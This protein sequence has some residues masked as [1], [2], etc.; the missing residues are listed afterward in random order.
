MPTAL[1]AWRTL[2]DGRDRAEFYRMW[3]AGTAAG[4]TVPAT[5][6]AMGPRAAA[7]VEE[8][9]SWLLTG[10]RDGRDVGSLVRLGRSRFDA[11]ESTLLLLGDETGSLE[12]V[13]RL[14]AEFYSRKHRL[15]LA[16]RKR[17]AY[18]L[19]TAMFATLIAPFPLLYFGHAVA[20]VAV[21]TAGMAF[22]ILSGGAIV[23]AVANRYGRSPAMVRARLARALATA[24][25]AGLPLARSIRLAADASAD[26]GVA[27]Y[28]AAIDERTLGTQPVTVTLASCPTLTPDF[29]AVLQVAEA[30]GDFSALTRLAAQYEDG[31]R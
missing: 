26:A 13:M 2:E 23:A 16:V 24:I 22:W 8:L 19:F 10:A 9:R 30:T 20:Y 3:Q 31:F 21:V 15:M 28:V 1:A 27:A 12:K 5:L 17:M 6:E 18:P 4:L 11:F 7:R 29:V 14:L 25:E